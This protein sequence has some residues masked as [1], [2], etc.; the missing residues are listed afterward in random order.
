MK[1]L[2]LKSWWQNAYIC[3]KGEKNRIEFLLYMYIIAISSMYLFSSFNATASAH[4]MIPLELVNNLWSLHT[5]PQVH[6]SSA[7]LQNDL[8]EKIKA[9]IKNKREKKSVS[10]TLLYRILQ[11]L[12][13]GFLSRVQKALNC[14]WFFSCTMLSGCSV[15]WAHCSRFLTSVLLKDSFSSFFHPFLICL[16]F[17]TLL[18]LYLIQLFSSYSF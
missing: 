13:A 8:T 7:F 11:C 9:K 15:L 18:S 6:I 1:Y 5:F 3:N 17:P 14:Q 2:Q 4:A 12:K 10:I 16:F